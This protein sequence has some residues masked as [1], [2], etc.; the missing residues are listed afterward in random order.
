M[1]ESQQKP[2]QHLRTTFREYVTHWA[3]AGAIVTTTGFA[4]DHWV[5]HLLHAI[6]SGWRQAFPSGIDYR[7][8]VV[9]LGVLMIVADVVLRNRRRLRL[10]VPATTSSALIDTQLVVV[11]Q[12]TSPDKQS[13]AVLPFNNLSN[14]PEQAYF[15]EGLTASLTTDLSRIS[16]LFVIASATTATLAGRVIDIRQIGRDLGVRYVLQGSVQ[17][18]SD[19][20]RVNAQLIEAASGAQLWSDRFDGGEAD[21]FALQ[22][23]ITGRIANSIGRE[24]NVRAAVDAEKRKTN[25]QATDFLI[26]GIALADKP[27]TLEG[28]LEQEE[29]FRKALALDPNNSDAWARLGRA[30]LMQRT[31]FGSIL[32]SEQKDEKLREGR[33]A[34]EKAIALDSKSARAHLAEGV[35]YRVLG[36]NAASARAME[37]AVALDRN[38]AIAHAGVGI[39]LI[40]V[41]EPEK[42]IPWIEQAMRLDPLG[43]QIDIHQANMGRA[44][45]LQRRSDLAIEWLLKAQSSNPRIPRVYANLAAAYAQKGD[46]AA[47]RLTT[48]SLLRV[49]PN[50]K[51]S[52]DAFDASGPF[53]PEAYRELYQQ[54]FL[55]AAR[56]AGIPE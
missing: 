30:I 20:L 33:K 4:P 38:L 3:V 44:Y 43:P 6:P 49:A 50:F 5:A 31:N 39:A 1:T 29:L 8:V 9:C 21:L 23:Q 27:H 42:A 45:F 53:S 48:D 46:D 35:L 52:D 2:L 51:I 11:E 56:K 17:R 24:I 32:L 34:V 54:V 16:G 19:R 14:D 18:G 36:N 25:P 22:D 26:R 40:H 15:T 47:A 7:L 10:E 55:P 28:L 13:I 37:A 12:F 41:G